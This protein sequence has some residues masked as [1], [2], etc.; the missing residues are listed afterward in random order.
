MKKLLIIATVLL[1][2]LVVFAC[3]FVPASAN[4]I[5]SKAAPVTLNIEKARFLNMLNRNY[6]YNSDFE[7]V[8]VMTENSILALLNRRAEDEYIEENIVIGFVNDM[9]GINLESINDNSA[10]H[11]DGF[12]YIAPH[13]FSSYCHEIIEINENEDGSFTVL[14]RVTV[15][16]HDDEAYVANAET[17]FVKNETSAFGYNIVYSNIADTGNEM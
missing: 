16:P 15:S 5:E 11:R 8:D 17:L 1:S 14:S 7:D 12:V 10:H 9:Y 2:V 4:E 6:V 13:G 3:A